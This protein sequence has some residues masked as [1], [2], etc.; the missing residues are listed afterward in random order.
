MPLDT[1]GCR[2]WGVWNYC[3]VLFGE[4]GG[5]VSVF[6]ECFGGCWGGEGDGLVRG[7]VSVFP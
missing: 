3:G 7:R 2:V 5:Y 1:S 4:G 6:G